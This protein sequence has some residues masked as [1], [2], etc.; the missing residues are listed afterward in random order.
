[1]S[2]TCDTLDWVP[3]PV[4]QRSPSCPSSFLVAGE[5]R[6]EG[7]GGVAVGLGLSALCDHSTG[8]VLGGFETS[9]SGAREGKEEQI[10]NLGTKCFDSVMVNCSCWKE[11]EEEKITKGSGWG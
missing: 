4:P 1:M 8:C 6:R 3:P 7:G 11:E 9:Q 10:G 5:A 2:L